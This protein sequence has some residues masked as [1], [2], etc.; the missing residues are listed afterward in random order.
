VWTHSLSYLC[1]TA[2]TPVAVKRLYLALG[3]Q[4]RE[5]LPAHVVPPPRLEGVMKALL[6]AALC[7]LCE[8]SQFSCDCC[9]QTPFC[10]YCK[11]LG[12]AN[13]G[14]KE[15]QIVHTMAHVSPSWVVEQAKG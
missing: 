9:I 12:V 4:R 14:V 10:D 3:L 7:A 5:A 13:R 6:D 8:L 15:G 1:P 2:G 11:H